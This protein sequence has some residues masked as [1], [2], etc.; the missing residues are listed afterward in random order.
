MGRQASTIKRIKHIAIKAVLTILIRER[1]DPDIA[2]NFKSIMFL[3][4][5][6]DQAW[7]HHDKSMTQRSHR[8]FKSKI[9]KPCVI[10]P[11]HLT[12]FQ[13]AIQNSTFTIH[14][15]RYDIWAF[16]KV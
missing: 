10:H 9:T 14:S 12:I 3:D 15:L 13:G 4:D 5:I 2:S 16:E 7:S 11:A 8:H 1:Y 6:A